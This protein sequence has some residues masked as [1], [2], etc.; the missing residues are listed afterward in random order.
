MKRTFCFLAGMILLVMLIGVRLNGAETAAQYNNRIV[1]CQIQVIKKM[2]AFYESFK[3]RNPDE[4]DAKLNAL[5][6]QCDESLNEMASIPP[7]KGE[8]ELRERFIDLLKFYKAISMFEFVEYNK[9]LKKK[10]KDVTNKDRSAL[11]EMQQSIASRESLL[12]QA[13][14]DAQNAFAKKYKFSITHNVYQDQVDKK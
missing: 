9:V 7:Y 8:T 14:N 13:V 6:L 2:T 4:L 12:D 10:N 3:T 5:Q 1:N 11:N